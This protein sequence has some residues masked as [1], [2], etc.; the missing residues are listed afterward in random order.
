[1]GHWWCG[2]DKGKGKEQIQEDLEEPGTLMHQQDQHGG[3]NSSRPAHH[4][5][6]PLLYRNAIHMPFYDG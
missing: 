1:V 4:P 2:M 6:A 5:W 3:A